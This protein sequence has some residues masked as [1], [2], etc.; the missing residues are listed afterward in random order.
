[1][2]VLE[3][4][5]KS[6]Y[7]YQSLLKVI[8]HGKFGSFGS[9]LVEVTVAAWLESKRTGDPVADFAWP[10]QD[11]QS[12]VLEMSAARTKLEN[13]RLRDELEARMTN[14]LLQLN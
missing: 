9:V 1:L 4:I 5:C 12:M 10:R 8:Y 3:G 2:F 14:S 13:Q 6:I 7:L 11:Q